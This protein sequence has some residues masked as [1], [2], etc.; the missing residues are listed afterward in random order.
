MENLR[1]GSP[2]SQI[3]IPSTTVFVP[4]FPSMKLPLPSNVLN[5]NMVPPQEVM[6]TTHNNTTITLRCIAISFERE[7]GE[8]CT[9]SSLA[10]RYHPC[11][12]NA[13]PIVARP[14][15]TPSAPCPLAS[16]PRSACAPHRP[17][18][19]EPERRDRRTHQ[20]VWLPCRRGLLSRSDRS[21]RHWAS[22]ETLS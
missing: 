10:T 21:S 8:A 13:Q 14:P 17:N 22:A 2:L 20:P 9:A 1:G 7:R 3:S 15:V 16:Q 19:R 11:C 5:T 6:S 18:A 12:N 4:P